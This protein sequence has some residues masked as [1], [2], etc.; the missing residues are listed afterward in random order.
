[1]RSLFP[2]LR[3]SALFGLCI[4]AGFGA[5]IESVRLN[6]NG[7]FNVNGN[8]LVISNPTMISNGWAFIEGSTVS[9]QTGDFGR[10]FDS[11]LKFTNGGIVCAAA[12]GCGLARVTF[13]AAIDLV[14]VSNQTQF[15][16]DIN[17]SGYTDV[18]LLNGSYLVNGWTGRTLHD[19]K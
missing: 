2:A 6:I 9:F 8:T 16:S 12:N 5:T 10:G 4:S 1:M 18:V 3:A 19:R 17:V 7:M 14:N 11:Q 15:A 13:G